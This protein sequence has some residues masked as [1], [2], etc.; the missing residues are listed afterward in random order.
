MDFSGFEYAGPGDGTSSDPSTTDDGTDSTI[1]QLG[2]LFSTLGAT[3]AKDFNAIAGPTTVKPGTVI[4]NPN[5][6]T[7]VA[8]GLGNLGSGGT[9]LMFLGLAILI[10]LILFMRS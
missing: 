6:T 4:V 7:S 10:A 9:G 5:G 2:G 3:V 1:A 8:G